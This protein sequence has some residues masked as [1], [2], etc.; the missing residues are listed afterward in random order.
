M[1]SINILQVISTINLIFWYIIPLTILLCIYI[2]IGLVLM[3]TT[4][5]DSIIHSTHANIHFNNGLRSKLLLKGGREF[6]LI[7]INY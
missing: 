1:N 2:T 7:P 6:F 4:D 3:R 5:D